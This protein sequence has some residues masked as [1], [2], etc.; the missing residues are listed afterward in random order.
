MPR[1]TPTIGQD[2]LD[3]NDVKTSDAVRDRA[4]GVAT[5]PATVKPAEE[6]SDEKPA[7]PTPKPRKPK[8]EPVLPGQIRATI[9]PTS[10]LSKALARWIEDID[11]AYR[12]L[13]NPSKELYNFF[14]EHDSELAKMFTKSKATK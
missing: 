5:T 4:R 11:P 3:G 12:D 2:I 8:P 6:K 14:K 10:K 9:S 7:E 1:K 13:V